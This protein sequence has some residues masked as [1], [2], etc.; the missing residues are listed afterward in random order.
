MMAKNAQNAM[1]P[2]TLSSR[3]DLLAGLKVLDERR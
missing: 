2:D 3:T 1:V